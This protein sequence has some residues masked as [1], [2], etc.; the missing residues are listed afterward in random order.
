MNFHIG[1][2]SSG[3]FRCECMYKV[4]CRM[5]ANNSL[6]SI[7]KGVLAMLEAKTGI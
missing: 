4:E 5:N 2:F 1:D 6:S 7:E 3:K